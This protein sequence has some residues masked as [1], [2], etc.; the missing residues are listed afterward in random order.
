MRNF[1]R[2]HRRVT[3]PARSFQ[4]KAFNAVRGFERMTGDLP[5]RPDDP[6][7]L[8][9][10]AKSVGNIVERLCDAS[11]IIA[12]H[13]LRNPRRDAQVARL[14]ELADAVAELL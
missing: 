3:A 5:C 10:M 13:P 2:E 9:A 4:R 8:E 6:A 11:W 12:E 1:C 14:E 7:E